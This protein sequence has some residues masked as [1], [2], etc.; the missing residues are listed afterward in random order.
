MVA[1][2]KR[3]P[4]DGVEGDPKTRALKKKKARIDELDP[5]RRELIEDAQRRFAAAVV[6]QDAYPR[7]RVED[8]MIC[9]A[10]GDSVDEFARKAGERI[11]DLGI[12]TKLTPAE[13]K[14]VC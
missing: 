12:S 14:L 3:G 1:A 4:T 13:W 6:T 9:K 5:I 8:T 10:F 2:P 11:E 7:D